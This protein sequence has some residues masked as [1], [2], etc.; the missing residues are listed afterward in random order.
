MVKSVRK[1]KKSM[2]S[3]RG[4]GLKKKTKSFRLKSR[5]QHK[6]GSRKSSKRKNRS[7][8]RQRGGNASVNSSPLPTVSETK[9][10]YELVEETKNQIKKVFDEIIKSLKDIYDIFNTTF[11]DTE[12]TIKERFTK[13]R[14]V[15]IIY[16]EFYKQYKIYYGE[17]PEGLKINGSEKGES[18]PP[19]SGESTPLS[20]EYKTR[21][22]AAL[23]ALHTECFY[24]LTPNKAV[25]DGL[26]ALRTKEQG[27]HTPNL[28]KLT[29]AQR[30]GTE[31]INISPLNTEQ[32]KQYNAAFE[33]EKKKYKG[34]D[35][36]EYDNPL[37]LEE[38]LKYL[39]EMKEKSERLLTLV[40]QER[41]Q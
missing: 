1:S 15:E 14:A 10:K 26:V 28:K 11:R 29:L 21:I 18:T 33:K 9:F 25:K 37:K 4:G 7:K 30:S 31:P 23:D 27:I 32:Y 3:I 2:K 34:L 19:D 20:K 12:I 8:K 35:P 22:E 40:N 6:R 16:E 13:E 17:L 39:E 36:S 38:L 5:S 41:P 24:I